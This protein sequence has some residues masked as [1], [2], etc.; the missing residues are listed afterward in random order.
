MSTTQEILTA[1]D[2][3]TTAS[4][5]Q[6]VASQALAQEVAGKMGE[7]DAT[8][9]QAS[10]EFE[11]FLVSHDDRLNPHF[12]RE[13][14]YIRGYMGV[15]GQTS[16]LAT[17]ISVA[18][19]VLWTIPDYAN[20]GRINN[21]GFEGEITIVRYGWTPIAGPYKIVARADYD[22]ETLG[23][24]NAAGEYVKE[25]AG[26]KFDTIMLNGTQTRIIIIERSGGGS[27]L[28]DV[29]GHYGGS[30]H[31][32]NK[33]RALHDKFGYAVSRQADGSYTLNTDPSSASQL[34]RTQF[35]RLT[36]GE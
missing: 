12:S 14:Y 2:A 6:T 3:S 18:G 36:F 16:N 31:S 35:G 7:I 34:L 5:E 20:G 11:Q 15:V 4:V 29:I 32:G 26:V 22:K 23:I 25:Y 8:L 13:S 27:A 17:A 33:A 19:Y 21:L 28:L 9:T 10:K 24:K 1:L 30:G